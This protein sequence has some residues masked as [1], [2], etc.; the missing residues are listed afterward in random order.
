MAIFLNKWGGE[1]VKL[2]DTTEKQFYGFCFLL[3]W[4][5]KEKC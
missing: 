3:Q 1:A 5:H 4:T 2:A